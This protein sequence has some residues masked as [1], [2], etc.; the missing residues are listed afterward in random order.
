MKSCSF[1]RR[2]GTRWLILAALG[3]MVVLEVG[4]FS[5]M[6]NAHGSPSSN[7]TSVVTSPQLL[8]LGSGQQT[9]LGQPATPSL[10]APRLDSTTTG[11]KRPTIQTVTG[12]RLALLRVDGA[13]HTYEAT[14]SDH[15]GGPVDGVD[16]DLGAL[17]ADPDIRV[18][19]T[20]MT[21][22]AAQGTYQV[23][24]VFPADG[25]WM[26]VVRVHA[27]SKA[28]ELF[29]ET[30]VGASSSPSHLEVQNSPSRRALR[31][32]DPTFN[33]RYNPVAAGPTGSSLELASIHQEGLNTTFANAGSTPI[34]N[35]TS[36]GFDLSS[37]IIV[38]VHSAAAGAW[39][40]AVLGLAFANRVNAPSAQTAI[41]Q[42]V[43]QRYAVL[44]GG[45]LATVALT[46]LIVS[47]KVSAGLAHPSQLAA[48]NLGVA[49]LA[50][51][52]LKMVLVAGGIVTSWRIG[53]L[54]PTA[55]QFN[56]RNRLASVGAMA[57]DDPTTI[58]NTRNIFRLAE[59]NLILGLAIIGC[60]GVL[61][62]LHHA[63]Q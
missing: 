18:T 43:A 30:V 39:L 46:G 23:S 52:G 44:A 37:T 24:I 25:D 9:A 58:P 13:K 6:A 48:T 14:I 56:L 61:G 38:V 60:V 26:L 27:P 57:N 63:I 50:I 49:Y 62:Q 1:N 4:L 15:N 2:A 28:V 29:T 42:F 7:A 47:L 3:V 35:E 54:M 32:A 22:A 12:V 16:L 8:A 10:A 31:A 17:Q 59:T 55:R 20:P 11:N 45:G 19:T 5:P 33:A 41:F 34:H 51:F 40:L 36:H 53:L 21:P